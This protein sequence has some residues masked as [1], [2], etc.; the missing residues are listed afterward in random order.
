MLIGRKASATAEIFFSGRVPGII[1]R[2]RRP[3]GGGQR[4]GASAG[5]ARGRTG[6]FLIK[7]K[8]PYPPPCENEI[9]QSMDLFTRLESGK[10]KWGECIFF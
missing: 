5:R 3:G 1:R 10:N 7:R 9:F 6:L 2:P 8:L 4:R